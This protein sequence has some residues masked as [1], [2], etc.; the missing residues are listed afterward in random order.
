M[1]HQLDVL[2]LQDFFKEFLGNLDWGV[3]LLV[4]LGGVGLQHMGLGFQVD[5]FLDQ[6]VVDLGEFE[7]AFPPLKINIFGFHIQG[8]VK[9]LVIFQRHPQRLN[10]QILISLTVPNLRN[11]L[12]IVHLQAGNN[13][14]LL[15]CFILLGG[16]VLALQ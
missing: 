10:T 3:L 16:V 1:S 8:T 15:Q 6:G 13:K 2:G 7:C 5:Y 11:I 12:P 9:I 14:L 4:G